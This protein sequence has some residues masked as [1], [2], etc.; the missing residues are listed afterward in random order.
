MTTEA[1]PEPPPKQLLFDFFAGKSTALQKQWIADWLKESENRVLYYQYLNE[2]ESQHPQYR[3]DVQPALDRFRAAVQQVETTPEPSPFVAVSRGD[4]WSSR[5]IWFWAASVLLALSIGGYL[6]RG[7]IRYETY[8]TAYGE[9]RTFKLS[10]GTTVALNANSTL[11]VPRWRFGQQGREVKLDGEAEFSVSHLPNHQRFIVRTSTDFAVEVLGT[12][13]VV[14]ARDQRR[15]VI[16]SRG[17][18]KVLY[19]PGKQLLMKPG[20]WIAL[21]ESG[22]LQRKITA[23]P[24]KFSSW[25]QHRFTFDQTSVAEICQ[26]IHENFGLTVRVTDSTLAQRQ[27]SGVFKAEKPDELVDDLVDLLQARLVKNGDRIDIQPI[28]N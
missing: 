11:R 28:V 7:V 5:S 26:L 24:A 15:K 14:Y 4:S 20:D 16:L 21:S 17:Q 13:F 19:Q 6:S 8:H 25:K 3:A 18:V 2:W 1:M 27:I 23:Q 9:T 12:E 10:D 22:Q